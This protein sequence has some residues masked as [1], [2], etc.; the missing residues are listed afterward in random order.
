MPRQADLEG[1]R[2]GYMDRE[3]LRALAEHAID[4][5]KYSNIPG[6]VEGWRQ[7][8]NGVIFFDKEVAYAE[9]FSILET[10]ISQYRKPSIDGTVFEFNFY[11]PW[12][13]GETRRLAKRF[14]EKF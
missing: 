5:F 3:D 7:E 8:E 9:V 10:A 1:E 4:E 13:T 11:T 6:P 14:V 2:R 12:A